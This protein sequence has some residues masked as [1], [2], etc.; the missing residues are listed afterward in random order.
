MRRAPG[1]DLERRRARRFEEGGGQECKRQLDG[2]KAELGRRLQRVFPWEQGAVDLPPELANCQP[3]DRLLERRTQG[4]EHRQHVPGR[5]PVPEISLLFKL[6]FP[7]WQYCTVH[8]TEGGKRRHIGVLH[9]TGSIEVHST[10]QFC[11][12]CRNTLRYTPGSHSFKVL[13]W[14]ASRRALQ[15]ASPRKV[16]RTSTVQYNRVHTQHSTDVVPEQR[17]LP[18]ILSQSADTAQHWHLLPQ[19]RTGLYF[20]YSVL[21]LCPIHPV[22]LQQVRVKPSHTTWSPDL[23][24]IAT[25]SVS[26][27]SKRV[28][29]CYLLDCTT[30]CSNHYHAVGAL[31]QVPRI[32]FWAVVQIQCNVHDIADYC[33]VILNRNDVQ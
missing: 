24:D 17:K 25:D 19:L 32:H 18:L 30:V 6:A 7:H 12:V 11:A 26:N 1:H 4:M 23:R 3:P 8:W 31:W 2:A 33:I 5:L 28:R 14:G 21:L 29:Y 15:I 16:P 27:S 20:L 22:K 9:V 13:T 10:V